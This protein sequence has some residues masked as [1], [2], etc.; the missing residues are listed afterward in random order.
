MEDHRNDGTGSEMHVRQY[1]YHITG[2]ITRLKH[3]LTTEYWK[4]TGLAPGHAGQVGE[5]QGDVSCTV[6]I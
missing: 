4:L 1:E 3:V 6:C 2:R 5:A